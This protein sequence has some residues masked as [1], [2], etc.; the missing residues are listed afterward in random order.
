MTSL[1][2]SLMAVILLAVVTLSVFIY[3]DAEE[4]SAIGNAPLAVGMLGNLVETSEAFR[5]A[6]GNYPLSID[7]LRTEFELEAVSSLE[8]DFIIDNGVACLSLPYRQDSEDLLQIAKNKFAGAVVTDTCGDIE[9][10][11][12][13]LLAFSM[14]GTNVP[15]ATA[16]VPAGS[17]GPS[18]PSG[19]PFPNTVAFA[20]SGNIGEDNCGPTDSWLVLRESGPAYYEDHCAAS[21]NKV[22]PMWEK[23]IPI[24]ATYSD[25]MFAGV[26]RVTFSAS[27]MGHSSDSDRGRLYLRCVDQNGHQLAFK[28]GGFHDPSNW[29][30]VSIAMDIPAQCRA[31]FGG[32]MSFRASGTQNSIYFRNFR[33]DVEG[34]NGNKQVVSFASFMGNDILSWTLEQ[35]DVSLATTYFYS[36]PSVK[37]DSASVGIASTV[38]D[39]PEEILLAVEASQASLDIST[40]VFNWSSQYDQG[41]IATKFVLD[42]GSEVDGPSTGNLAAP[43]SLGTMYSDVTGVPS[44][45]RAVRFIYETRRADGSNSDYN[46]FHIG[47]NFILQR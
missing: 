42:D 21:A 43:S 10:E 23:Q 4:A 36:F 7:D 31:V 46:P 33:Y 20:A 17:S 27:M 39:I 12:R 44:N 29:S 47:A 16:F 38:V 37:A 32:T 13:R 14:D 2:I 26:V 28:A 19:Y 9:P 41:R 22:S 11:G 18:G 25:E 35:G 24:P 34:G 40:L 45:A 6:R 1:M 5:Q 15:E 30:T 3:F 8:A